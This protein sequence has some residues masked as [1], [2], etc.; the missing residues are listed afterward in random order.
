MTPLERVARV[1]TGAEREQLSTAAPAHCCSK[2]GAPPGAV[3]LAPRAATHLLFTMK[4]FTQLCGPTRQRDEGSGA[5][6]RPLLQGHA[7]PVHAQPWARL[8]LIA[9]HDRRVGPSSD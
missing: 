4:I 7:I 2:V 9:P 1:A 5:G 8:Q 6:V 3:R